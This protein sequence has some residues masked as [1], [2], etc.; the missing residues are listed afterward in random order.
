MISL[1]LEA[2][3]TALQ[4]IS[5]IVYG[6]L[7]KIG[8]SLDQA[9]TQIIYVS[10]II[11]SLASCLVLGQIDDIFSRKLVSLT[12]GIAIGFFFFGTLFFM[13]IGF[14]LV[15]YLCMRMMERHL[16]A[17]VM[18]AFSV[19]CLMIASTYHL[20]YKPKD[21]L[22]WDIDLIFMINFVKVHMMAVNY[23]NAVKL[24]SDKGT[25]TSRER[26]YAEPLRQRVKFWD[27]MNYF[28]FVASCY[29]GMVCEYRQFHEFINK[30]GQFKNIPKEKLIGKAMTRASHV[31]LCANIMVVLEI[32]CPKE[33]MFT[34][35][36][37]EKNLA[38][39]AC[40]LIGVS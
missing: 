24:D 18:T 29:S 35:E 2:L 3:D 39:K 38:Y 23:D 15:N 11:L 16:A 19:V 36:F 37:A 5:E 21:N 6:P 4:P 34:P 28:F 9:L 12:T 32:M 27:F 14:V 8:D 17:N 33:F 7:E 40:F 13:N 26:F 31:V 22:T 20:H 1:Y 30:Q 10:A 25:M